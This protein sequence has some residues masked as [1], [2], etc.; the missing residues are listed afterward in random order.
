[1]SQP[2]FAAAFAV[3]Y[4]L[5]AVPSAP[6]AVSLRGLAHMPWEPLLLVVL[7]RAVPPRG[8]TWTKPVLVVLVTAATVVKVANL[9]VMQG[10]DRPFAPLTDLPMIPIALG[11]LAMNSL[12]VAIAAGAGAVVLIGAVAAAAAWSLTTLGR[13][14]AHWAG[15]TGALAAITLALSFVTT[16]D[17]PSPVANAATTSL[18]RAQAQTLAK[19]I[20][21][22]RVF[23]AALTQPDPPP[24]S[25][26]LASLRGVD[27]LVIFVESYGRSALDRAPY[28]GIVRPAL[29]DSTR[30]LAEA[31]FHASSAWLT[32]ATFG[33]Q[34]WLAHST[35][36]SGLPVT[37]DARYQALVRSGRSTLVADFKRAGWRTA[38]VMAEI[39]GP[40]PEGRF[41]GFDAAYTA[42][43]LGY[44]GPAFGYMTMPDQF[45]LHAFNQYEFA[46][47][48]RPPVMAEIALISSHIPWAPLPKFVPWD[49]VGDGA[50]FAT[51]RTPEA[52]RE[53]WEDPKRVQLFY[54]RSLEYV[55]R[56]VTS[57][58]TT[59]GRDNTLVILM[60]D[61]QPMGF[62]AG[63]NA[64]RQVPVHLIARDERLLRALDG[65]Q[66]ATGMTPAAAGPVTP[67]EAL[68]GRILAAFTPA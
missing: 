27:V 21:D 9:A 68:R 54:A 15:V 63:E 33:G 17:P 16:G 3:L 45:L 38:A 34:S 53:V 37:S 20:R 41:F 10:F 43:E 1:M 36:M 29:D 47:P 6:W 65:G 39:T 46:K 26:A 22:L 11:T 23:K 61:H 18:M 52:A 44:R 31:G 62:I 8:W 4:L 58:I 2:R 14:T 55:L 19:D 57:F 13:R 25:Q 42:H 60:G 56:T 40:W 59:F 28:D 24:H 7:A 32:S 5:F 66:W 48:G 12:L 50:V 30:A 64:G 49:E 51:A 35:V 67:M